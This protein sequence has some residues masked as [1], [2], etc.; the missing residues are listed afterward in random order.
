MSD[1]RFAAELDD[2]GFQ[3]G[4]TNLQRSSEQTSRAVSNLFRLEVFSRLANGITRV[5]GNQI[6]RAAASDA[7]IAALQEK[8][9]KVFEPLTLPA[10]REAMESLDEM[11]S[12]IGGF[13]EWASNLR[14]KLTDD[15]GQGLKTLTGGR[16]ESFMLAD[17][18]AEERWL[19]KTSAEQVAETKRIKAAEAAARPGMMSLGRRQNEEFER[20]AF[21]GTD[22]ADRTAAENKYRETLEQ[23]EA[24]QKNLNAGSRDELGLQAKKQGALRVYQLTIAELD[25][26]QEEEATKKYSEAEQE[27]LEKMAKE[28]ERI[29]EAIAARAKSMTSYTDELEAANLALAVERTGNTKYTE[30]MKVQLD[31]RKQMRAIEQD[32]AISEE[33]RVSLLE[34]MT[35]QE[36]EMLALIYKRQDGVN[37][38][39]TRVLGGGIADMSGVI[40]A[41]LFAPT[42]MPA[43]GA[44]GGGA[45]AKQLQAQQ[46]ANG[47][48]KQVVNNTARP[49]GASFQ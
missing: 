47:L 27:R 10:I 34:Q 20:L 44:A 4:L 6:S 35:K 8:L 30:M 37:R 31:Y 28:Q 46:T 25:R 16:S 3:R 12:G 21:A 43:S 33:D 7:G 17:A 18:R 19:K 14:G 11:S 39:G 32:T 23:I 5:M 40:A 41:Q 42:N 48:L 9:S 1:L 13:L 15:L 29:N 26:K 22:T 49:A 24:V 38:I 45:A 36:E 2:K